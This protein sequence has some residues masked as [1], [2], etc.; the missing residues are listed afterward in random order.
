MKRTGNLLLFIAILF[1][2]L[3]CRCVGM[4]CWFVYP[5]VSDL[6]RVATISCVMMLSL[7]ASLL[8]R[9]ELQ[10]LAVPVMLY[11]LGFVQIGITFQ[12]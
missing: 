2:N 12:R 3:A 9:Y 4:R 11:Q 8:R 5:H 1:C 7:R 10:T 6:F